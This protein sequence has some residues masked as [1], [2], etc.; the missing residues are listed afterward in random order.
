MIR[1][2]PM[3][4]MP[5]IAG[6]A[7]TVQAAYDCMAQDVDPQLLILYKGKE[8][9]MLENLNWLE[10]KYDSRLRVIRHEFSS[11]AATWNFGLE[12]CWRGGCSEALVVNNDVRLWPGTFGL[13]SAVRHAMDAMLVSGVN[14][15]KD[16]YKVDWAKHGPELLASAAQGTLTP[17]GPDFSC[18]VMSRECHEK[19]RFDEGFAPAY[20]EDLDLH[21]RMMLAGD[22][23]KI[24]GVPVPY[25]HIDGGSGTLKNLSPAGRTRLEEQVE[26]VSRK[27][28]E[29]KWGGPVNQERFRA[30]FGGTMIQ[31]PP[32]ETTTP[33]LQREVWTKKESTTEPF[34]FSGFRTPVESGS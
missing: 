14:T 8:R 33:D 2:R 22:G 13:L 25:D 3:V 20:A 28:Y 10:I 12:E 11:L 32:S 4:V 24:F 19:Y 34:G 9:Q 29:R 21:R 7:M 27:Y 17:G 31:V 6:S 23:R 18:F 1:L 5:V 26:R 30:P 16:F 15:G